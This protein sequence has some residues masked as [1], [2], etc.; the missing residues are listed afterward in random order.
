[1]DWFPIVAVTFKVLVLGIGM[2]F[3]VKW[4]FDQGQK[5]KAMDKR[6]VMRAAAKVAA[7]FVLALLGV[8]LFAFYLV[9]TF[10]LDLS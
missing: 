8:G 6:A 4:H 2:F 10:G 9:R 7:I 5:E 1:M 3:A